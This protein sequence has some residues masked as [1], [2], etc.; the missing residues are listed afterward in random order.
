MHLRVPV[1]KTPAAS[2]IGKPLVPLEVAA[3]ETDK[4]IRVKTIKHTDCIEVGHDKFDEVVSN[5]LIK[6]GESNMISI[7]TLDLH[8]PGHRHA[9]AADRLRRDDRLSGLARGLAHPARAAPRLGACSEHAPSCP[10]PALTCLAPVHYPVPM[11]CRSVRLLLIAVC[12]LA[13]PFRAPAPLIYRPGEGWTYEP[14][15]GEGKWQQPRAK[16]QLEVAQAAFDKKAYSLAL[17]AARRVVQVWPLSDYAPQ[18]QYLVAR[19]YEADRQGGKGVQGLPD[20]AG[21]A[22]QDCELRGDSAAPISRSPTCIS[23][24]SGSSCGATFPSSASMER[25]AKMYGDIVKTGPY[26]DVAPQAQLNIGHGVGK[27]K[28]PRLQDPRLSR[29]RQGLRSRPP[30]VIT[31]SPRWRPR[32]SSG[33]AWLTRNRR[34]PPDRDQGTAGQAIAK[35]TD[36][37]ALY[38]NDPRVP[39]AQKI[40]ASLKGE[41]ARGNFDD[42]AV[43][44]EAQEVGR[45]A[46]LLQRGA[47][48][49]SQFALCGRSAATH[50]PTQAAGP[51]GGQIA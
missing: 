48:A 15:G 25:T 50:R 18:A 49:G 23:P 10:A 30:T 39:Q 26:S 47:V 3:K 19:C 2:L 40:I 38:P 45:R 31:T 29:R 7:T 9:E 17:K 27:A 51:G 24:A 36:F 43:L 8:A 32:R 6:I 41:Q 21:E 46:D 37:M 13:F 1:H 11:S 14:V 35:F 4:K 22:A 16:D 12:L 33:P 34:K 28:G 20:A 5:F 44:R 42:R